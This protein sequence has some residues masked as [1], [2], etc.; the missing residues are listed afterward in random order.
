MI[1]LVDITKFSDEELELRI[2]RL[3]EFQKKAEQE[4]KDFKVVIQ[5]CLNEM[6]RRA[7]AK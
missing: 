5:D 4:A 6:E 7:K 2:K 3:I 1:T